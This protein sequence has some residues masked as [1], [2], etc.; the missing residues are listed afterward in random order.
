[1][2]SKAKTRKSATKTSGAK[3][4]RRGFLTGAVAGAAAS[5]TL[6]APAIAQGKVRWKMLTTW[7]KNFPGVGTAAQGVADRIT[8]MSDGQLDIKLFAAGEI[9]PAFEMFDAVRDGTA[10]CG[11]DAPYYW[12]A[13]HKAAPFFCTVPGGLTPVEQM[14]WIKHGGGQ[15]LWDELYGRFGLRAWMAGNA[16]MQFMGWFQR[17]IKS[18]DD[19]QGLKIR[20]AGLH[21]EVFN[22]M[23]ATA[24]NLPG[25]EIMPALQSGVIEAAEWGGPYMDVAFGFYKVVKYCYGPS[26][27]EPG[28]MLSFVV[29]QEAFEDLPKHLQ[30]IVQHAAEAQLPDTL[31]QFNAL[32]A[33]SLQSLKE[34][35]DVTPGIFP[36]DVLKAWFEKSAEVVAEAAAEDELAQRI[37]DSWSAYRQR[38]ME[39]APYADYGFMMAR[40][41]AAIG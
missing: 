34:K 5:T 10:E 19:L 14:G 17:E 29:N 38:A 2:S 41:R 9:V 6:A 33:V 15:E 22:R 7:P 37:Y 12:V 30:L 26:A 21:A 36:D 8:A 31:G 40:E 28:A 13:K 23:G 18:L 27:H 35:Y 16:G 1:M 39:L 24:V 11:H 4:T 20:M 32:N 3:S 25:G